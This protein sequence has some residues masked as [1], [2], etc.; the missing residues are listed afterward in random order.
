MFGVGRGLGFMV[1]SLGFRVQG[2]DPKL[3]LRNWELELAGMRFGSVTGRRR[4]QV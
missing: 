2:L 3:W 4:V 1:Q